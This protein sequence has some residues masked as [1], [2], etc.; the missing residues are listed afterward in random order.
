VA[1]PASLITTDGAGRDR[2]RSKLN[3]FVWRDPR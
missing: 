2:W 3:Q 1:W